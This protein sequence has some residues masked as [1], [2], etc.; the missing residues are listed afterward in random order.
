MSRDRIEDIL[1]FF[2]SLQNERGFVN[3]A[4]VQPYGFFPDW[5]AT[6]QSGPDG[7]GTP[8]Y[9][10]MLLAG[11]FAAGARLARAWNDE[12]AEA[13]YRT[14]A[15]RLRDSIRKTFWQPHE[16]LYSNGLDRNG[17][18]DSRKTSFAQAFAVV[19]DIAQPDEYDSL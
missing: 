12:A 8:A 5:S 6:Q 9:G 1:R 11:A 17:N 15:A 13:R 18:L 19:F 2:A 14:A 10:Q 3:A 16:G 7:H 4:Q